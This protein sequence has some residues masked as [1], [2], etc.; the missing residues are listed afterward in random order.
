MTKS[1]QEKIKTIIKTLC[2]ELQEKYSI[3]YDEKQIDNIFVTYNELKDRLKQQMHSP[4][5]LLDRHK[6][7]AL[8]TFAIVANEPFKINKIDNPSYTLRVANYFVALKTALAILALFKN[9]TNFEIDKTYMQEFFRLLHI[10]KSTIQ[11]ICKNKNT[12]IT[13]LFFLSH[14]YYFIDKCD[15][16]LI[17]EKLLF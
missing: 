2:N 12:D 15:T 10:N 7:A 14:L 3:T 9:K 5:K 8:L 11:Q 1:T 16:D 6:I 17:D 4:D 13:I